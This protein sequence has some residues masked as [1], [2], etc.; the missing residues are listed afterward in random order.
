MFLSKVKYEN[1]IEE[2]KKLKEKLVFVQREAEDKENFFKSFLESFNFELTKTIDQHELVNSQHHVMG[3]L[4]AKIKERFDKVNDLCSFSFD[5]SKILSEKGES[6][7]ESAKDMVLK[8]EEGRQ[9]V[10]MVEKLI[11]QL[12]N[13]LGETYNKMNQLNERSKEIELIVKVI[14]EIA[15]QTNLL[16]LN[17]SI[18]AARAGEQGKGFAVVADEVRKLAEN[19]AVSTNSISELTKNIQKDIQETLSSTTTSTELVNNGITLSADTTQKIVYITS[20]IT[21]VQTEV[22]AVNGKIEEQKVYSQNVMSEITNTKS[23][24]DEVNEVILKH[25]ND[26]NVVD[27]KLE[28][29]MKQVNQLNSKEEIIEQSEFPEKME[30]S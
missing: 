19:T 7:I 28:G 13:Q 30:V 12:G 6:L 17:A 20:V 27:I 10:S 25:I 29:A 11:L 14:K 8:T 18:E 24:F 16:A 3:D 4:V 15:D 21:N 26:A 22:S 2:N 23:L 5:N 9:S 1:L